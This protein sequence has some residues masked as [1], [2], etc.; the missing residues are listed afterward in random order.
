MKRWRPQLALAAILLLLPLLLLWPLPLV[1]SVDVLAAPGFEAASHI[2]GL[3]A[4]AQLHQPLVLHTDLLAWPDGITLVLVDPINIPAFALGD[5][6]AGP[7]LGFNLVAWS[8]LVIAGLAGALLAV[9]VQA[10]PRV[11]ALAAMCAP[12]LVSAPGAGLTEELALGWVGL[13]LALLLRFRRTARPA[14]GIAAGL[15]LGACAWAGPYALLLA[16]LVDGVVGLASL[17]ER[18]R[19]LGLLAI[20]GLGLC[21]AMPVILA[22]SGRTA[23]QPGGLA[24][25]AMPVLDEGPDRFRGGLMSGLDLLD[26]WLP[27]PLT[28]GVPEISHTGY[29]GIVVLAAAI[30][31]VIRQRNLWPW[32]AGAVALSALALGPHLVLGGHALRLGGRPLLGPAGLLV[33][34]LPAAARL[35]RWYRA[36]PVAS[37]L[38]APLAARAVLGRPRAATL[39]CVGILLDTLLLAPLPWPLPHTP[40]PHRAIWSQPLDA[41]AGAI[42]ELPLTTSGTPPTGRWRDAGPLAQTLHKRSS[43]ASM[44]GLPP[45][46]AARAGQRI[47]QKLLRTGRLSGTD[48]GALRRSGFRLVALRTTYLQMGPQAA[49][50]LDDCL[51][52]PIATAEGLRIHALLASASDCSSG[53]PETPDAVQY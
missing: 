47:V 10:S 34:V 14:A 42:L 4:A 31:A 28:G 51:G 45:A 38:L 18:K 26:A 16:A 32:L 24:R 25:A 49:R 43:S 9:E 52:P 7:A 21:L 39:L 20:G 36:A 23:T 27:A 22:I 30:F 48:R 41:E 40:L 35:T 53:E 50:R 8:S 13:Q 1:G 11:G 33:L 3:W 12:A 29:L 2:W 6:I 46:G 5:A 17:R 37:L 15:C 19:L 44:M